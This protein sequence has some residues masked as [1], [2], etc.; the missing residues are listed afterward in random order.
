MVVTESLK[1]KGKLVAT[2]SL[3][4]LANTPLLNAGAGGKI[5]IHVSEESSRSVNRRIISY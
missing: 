4:L 3:T 2:F 1:L 5:H